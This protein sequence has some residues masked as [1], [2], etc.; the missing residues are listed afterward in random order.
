[1]CVYR[2]YYEW[3][4]WSGK[5]ISLKKDLE[6]I[7]GRA[8]ASTRVVMGS[9]I[10]NAL[11]LKFVIDFVLFELIEDSLL[12][13]PCSLYLNIFLF[14]ACPLLSLLLSQSYT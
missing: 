11:T 1:M 9:N 2:L 8:T 14:K 10:G 5:F 6:T 3:Q 4:E 13:L 12:H 7:K